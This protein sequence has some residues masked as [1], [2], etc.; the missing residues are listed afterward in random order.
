MKT[1]IDITN[2]LEIIDEKSNVKTVKE[3]LTAIEAL[4]DLF[5]L[6]YD[7]VKY[8]IKE[9]K[10]DVTA[11]EYHPD[12]NTK[13]ISFA[14][15]RDME[16]YVGLTLL[17]KKDEPVVVAGKIRGNGK[18]YD[19]NVEERVS[20]MTMFLPAMYATVLLNCKNV[21]LT[22]EPNASV[23]QMLNRHSRKPKTIYKILKINPLRAK[24]KQEHDSIE[25][26]TKR[27]L[28]TC[29]GHLRTYTDD[30][31]LFG[32]FIGT[33]F[34]PAHIRGSEEFGK[35]IKDYEFNTTQ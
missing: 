21:S 2:L 22:V 23:K 27:S 5:H 12:E 26:G 30:K 20:M 1:S 15:I 4:G 3:T 28:H 24:T 31:K 19:V 29:R 25:T 18:D 8:R 9:I 10:E 32:R 7:V 16:N 6:P 17:F 33:Y 34:I 35:V 11:I 13:T 14:L